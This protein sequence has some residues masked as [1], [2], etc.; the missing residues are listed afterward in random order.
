MNFKGYDLGGSGLPF[1]V[2]VNL[3]RF[4]HRLEKKR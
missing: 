1:F 3:R 4:Y 2:P